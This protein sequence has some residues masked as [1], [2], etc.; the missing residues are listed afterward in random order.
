M[1]KCSKV[2]I[3]LIL[4][5]LFFNSCRSKSTRAEQHSASPVVIS[6]L[7]IELVAAEPG[8]KLKEQYLKAKQAYT[9]DPNSADKIIWYGRR[10]AYLGNFADAVSIYTEGIVKFPKDARFYR[11]R[12]HRYISLR[13]FDKA[14]QD[15]E[16]AGELIQGTQNEIEPDGMPNVQNIPVS[17]LHGNVWYHLGLAYYLVHNY[18]RAY[19]A[20][21]KCRDSGSNADN[22]VSSTHWLYM[23][24]RRLGNKELADSL[25]MPIKENSEVIENT[26]YYKLCKFYKGL[27][28]ID[29]L[30]PTGNSNAAS[31]AIKYGLA[32][33]YFY[34]EEKEKSKEL[35]EELLRGDS[36]SSFGYIAAESDLIHYFK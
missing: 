27:L 33:W 30:S 17:S 7:G 9:E 24:Q 8:K 14:I 34:N 32:N 23:I 18:Q 31:D 1:H 13:K 10:T 36:W 25:L 15:F 11:H 6:P 2:V 22:V 5:A 4:S 28:P 3:V 26:N 12:G 20:Y 21:L 19:E 16:K 29:S 35:L